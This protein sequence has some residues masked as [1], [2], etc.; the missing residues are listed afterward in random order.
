MTPRISSLLVLAALGCGSA[1]ETSDASSDAT[2]DAPG[3]DASADVEAAAPPPKLAMSGPI[4]IK[5]QSDAGFS[6]LHVVSDAGPCVRIEGSSH[7][8]I[9]ASEIG[10][11]GGNGIELSKDDD[12]TIAD[13]YI[14]PEHPASGCCDTGDGVYGN[15]IT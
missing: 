3:V 8:V 6:G 4:V 13:S 11:C 2:S 14:H 5:N 9:A 12:V 1:T 7:V 10:P 15:T